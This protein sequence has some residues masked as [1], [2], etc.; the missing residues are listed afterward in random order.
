MEKSVER[1]KVGDGS[2]CYIND[3]I[4]LAKKSEEGME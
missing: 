4:G 3:E 2:Y 1:W